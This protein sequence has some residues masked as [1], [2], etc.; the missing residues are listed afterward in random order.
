MSTSSQDVATVLH[1]CRDIITQ[2]PSDC[3]I[4]S[5]SV[6]LKGSISGEQF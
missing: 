3:Q 5:I 1:S 4:I 2:Y 6:S